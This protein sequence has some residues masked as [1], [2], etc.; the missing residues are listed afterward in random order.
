MGNAQTNE[1]DS[2]LDELKPGTELLQGQYKIEKFINS[3][4]FGITYLATDSLARKVVIKE[5]FPSSFCHRSRAIV[6]AR[7][8]AHSQE[9]KS[10][11]NLFVQEA[12]S[13]AKL[14]H[15]NIVGVHQVFEDNETA[16]MVLDFVEGRDLLDILEDGGHELTPPQIK[17]ILKDVLGAVKFIHE[18]DILH[19]DISPDNILLDG[20]LRPVLI[21]F[22]AAREEATKQSR[23]LSALRVVKDGYSPQEFYVQGSEQSPSSDLYALGATFYHLISGD[24]PTNSQARLAAIAS[25]EPDPYV[26]L[27]D[28][29]QGHDRRMLEAIDKALGILPKDRVQ[30]ADEWLDALEGRRRKSRIVTTP[31]MMSSAA[32][33]TE[34]AKKK[35]MLV[36]LLGSAAAIAII[37]VVGLVA[38]GSLNSGEEQG[39]QTAEVVDTGGVTEADI[40]AAEA[41]AAV[42]AAEQAAA[43]EE[44]I[45]LAEIAAAEAEIAAAEAEARQAELAIAAEVRAE[46][47]AEIA[48]VKAEA[49]RPPQKQK[50]HAL[51]KLPL[52]KPKK[53][54][55][56]LKLLPSRQ[57]QRDWLISPKRKLKSYDRLKR[58]KL[59]SLVPAFQSHAAMMMLWL[60]TKHKSLRL[61][62]QT[63]LTPWNSQ[64][65][66][67]KQRTRLVLSSQIPL[68]H[69]LA[70]YVLRCLI[71]KARPS[72]M[73]PF[74][75]SRLLS[76]NPRPMR[77]LTS[78]RPGF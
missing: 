46:R 58:L 24:I 21:D 54:R 55:L 12:R 57:K 47:E 10:V 28:N 35:S 43:E 62:R 31:V 11:V 66:I 48:A 16:Y 50:P 73:A 30:S 18:Q 37:A 72:L 77:R 13:L 17:G 68:K 38:T 75:T 51:P 15:P 65:R 45:R 25:G 32:V 41:E 26:P 5:C 8:R 27:A 63:R 34:M 70:L 59:L 3:G 22:G 61:W 9:L 14:D 2:F 67:P 19:R 1:D 56:K 40:A 42:L 39:V 76:L 23:V 71:K 74:L 20:D 36:P 64:S 53:P 29:T 33:E 69:Q 7:S 6:Q 44:A 4:G 52:L 49:E 78:T 60:S